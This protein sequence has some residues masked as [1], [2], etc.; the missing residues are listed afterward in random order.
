MAIITFGSEILR[1]KLFSASKMRIHDSDSKP[2]SA[3]FT[4]EEVK[5]NLDWLLMKYVLKNQT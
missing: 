4:G 5:K 3:H 1:S 2:G